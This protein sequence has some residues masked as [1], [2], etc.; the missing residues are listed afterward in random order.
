MARNPREVILE[1]SKEEKQQYT[2]LNSKESLLS[3]LS[4][5]KKSRER[6]V[7]SHVDKGYAFQIREMREHAELSQTELGALVDMNQNAV[8]RLESPRYGKATITSLKRMAAAFDVALVV[9]FVPFSQIIN[10]VSGTPFV[11]HGLF[12]GALSVPG[13]EEE[14]N[15]GAFARHTVAQSADDSVFLDKEL[16][17]VMGYIQPDVLEPESQ[18]T[19]AA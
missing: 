19:L 15:L 9:R 4:T 11:D 7:S 6:F 12:S 17:T 1:N 13:F 2:N 8:H 18:K 10:W 3:R 14:K 5:S 16:V